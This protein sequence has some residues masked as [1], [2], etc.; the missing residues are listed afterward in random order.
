MAE[1]AKLSVAADH[2]VAVACMLAVESLM[3][4]TH[5]RVPFVVAAV[6][7]ELFKSAADKVSLV[8]SSGPG[9]EDGAVP[10]R[11]RH[12]GQR[13]RERQ[14][15]GDEEND[16]DDNPRHRHHLLSACGLAEPR[17]TC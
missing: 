17:E 8:V 11:L 7:K 3:P 6:V 2:G 10:S 9:F 13:I 12:H 1:V 4:S 14:R 16:P 5:A 15:E